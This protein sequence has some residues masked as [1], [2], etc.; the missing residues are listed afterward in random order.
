MFIGIL[1]QDVTGLQIHTVTATL[2]G[3]F[4]KICVFDVH[5]S[6]FWGGND[7]LNFGLCRFFR[8][9]CAMPIHQVAP[10]RGLGKGTAAEG[11]LG[12]LQP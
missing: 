12:N 5:P 10:I 9:P 3:C 4:Q 7:Q 6:L 1:G 11:G 2:G 8:W